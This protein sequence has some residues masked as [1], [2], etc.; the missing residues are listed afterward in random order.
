MVRRLFWSVGLAALCFEAQSLQVHTEV[1]SRGNASLACDNLER[2]ESKDDLHVVYSTNL[3][4]VEGLK[5]SL[6]SLACT[7]KTPQA[8]TV[9]VLIQQKFQKYFKAAFGIPAPCDGRRTANGVVVRLHTIDKLPIIKPPGQRGLL[10]VENFARFYLHKL[11]HAK[12]AIY[13]DSDTIIKADLSPLRDQLLQSGKTAGFVE[14]ESPQGP[15]LLKEFLRSPKFCHWPAKRRWDLLGQRPAYN[16]GVF[17]ANLERWSQMQV[18]RRVESLIAQNGKCRLKLWTGVT[19]PPMLL[20]FFDHP[21]GPDDFVV[22]NSTWNAV[23]L[24]WRKKLERKELAGKNVLHWNR[25]GKPWK[26]K[27]ALYQDLWKPD[28]QRFEH[29]FTQGCS[30]IH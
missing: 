15:M 5:A 3:G 14:R 22:Y 8:L 4:E 16:I 9:H 28:R 11:I 6:A 26:L 2:A 24:G 12:V 30:K 20:A 23:D 18:A 7:A 29:L 21:K 27:G 1:T 13:L 10:A 17:A 19:Q 25:L